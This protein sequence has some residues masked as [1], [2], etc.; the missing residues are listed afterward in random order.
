MFK[1]T[2][3]FK[4]QGGTNLL[5]PETV[6]QGGFFT[7]S[8][9][10]LDSQYAYTDFISVLPSTSYQMRGAGTDQLVWFAVFYNSEKNYISQSNY[11]PLASTFTTPSG[12][13]YVILSI[14]SLV[15][16]QD[17]VNVSVTQGIGTPYAPYYELRDLKPY[18][19]TL[20]RVHKKESGEQFYRETL[21]GNIRLLGADYDFIKNAAFDQR[22]LLE[23]LD[24]DGFFPKYVSEFYKTDC[25][26]NDDDR[27]LDLKLE[28]VDDY[29]AIL[30]GLDKT[31]N[32]IEL[33]PE[34]NEIILKR[35]P[36]IQAYVPGE[37]GR[38][39]V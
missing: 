36:L 37:I 2:L 39:H 12:T 3:K 19:K 17:P 21:N 24:L 1:F 11:S 23:I 27:I 6:T 22:F 13:Y 8:G 30:G 7:S 35:R 20:D 28:T 26:W 31:F 25:E 4:S 5:N 10:V 9:V 32:L 29:K 15:N 33:T 34:L 18:Y 16:G 14:K 38:A